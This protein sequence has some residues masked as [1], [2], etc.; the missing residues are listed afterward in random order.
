MPLPFALAQR[1]QKRGI[2][3]TDAGE[4]DRQK[5]QLEEVIAEDYDDNRFEAKSGVSVKGCPNKYNIYHDCSLYC[6]KKYADVSEE[7]SPQTKRKYQRLVKRY[8]LPEGWQEVYDPGVHCFYYWK[9]ET[10]EVSWFP[11]HHPNAR[12][13][14]SA[15]KLRSLLRDDDDEQEGDGSDS[16]SQLSDNSNDNDSDSEES[17]RNDRN[18]NKLRFNDR[19]RGESQA[20][21]RAVRKANDLDPMDP[22]SY[23]DLPRGKWS[24]GLGQKGDAKSGVDSTASGPLFQMRPYPNPGAVLRLN[25]EKTKTNKRQQHDSSADQD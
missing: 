18:T 21:G 6:H 22:S 19:N 20:K 7:V 24:D 8:P 16:D 1:L 2:I 5:E 4:D 13:S 10:D 14:L 17:D 25:Q 12:I 23:S 15:D 3:T 11:P 9:T